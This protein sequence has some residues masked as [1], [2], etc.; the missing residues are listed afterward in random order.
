MPRCRSRLLHRTS[1]NIAPTTTA[2]LAEGLCDLAI[3]RTA[4]D[5]KRFASAIVGH[6]RRYCALAAHDPWARQRSIRLDEVPQRTVLIDRRTGTTTPDLWPATAQPSIQETR[7]I[8]DWLAII[9][10]GGG[11]GITPEGTT[12]RRKPPSQ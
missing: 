4:V 10:A 8:D 7:D 11:I 12:R 6:E 1:R 9:A 3:L 2:G 5:G